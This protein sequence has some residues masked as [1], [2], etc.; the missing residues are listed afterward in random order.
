MAVINTQ[1]DIHT[2]Y[3]KEAEAEGIR[4]VLAVPISFREDVIGILRLLSSD[5]RNF[6]AADINFAMAIA[7][8]TG[9]AIQRVL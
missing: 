4:S 7:D 5:I 8:Q 1:K 6:S 9:I 3:H 2:V